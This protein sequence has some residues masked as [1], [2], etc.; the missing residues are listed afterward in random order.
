MKSHQIQKPDR[1]QAMR[2]RITKKQSRQKKK[3]EKEKKR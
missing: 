3:I 1:I 2:G